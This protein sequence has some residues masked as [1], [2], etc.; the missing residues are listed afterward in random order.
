VTFWT[1][2]L[3]VVA[4]TV[5]NGLFAGAE[6]AVISLRRTRLRELV[7]EGNHA[8][9]LVTRLRHVPERFLATVQIGITVI[10]AT[11]AA[12]GGATLS[13]PVAEFFTKAGLGKYAPGLA[14]ASVIV[15]VSYLSLVLGELV[16]KSLALRGA[17]RYSLLVARPLLALAWVARPLVW[18]LTASSNL[19]L[20]FFG[21]R[22]NFVEARLSPEE[23][24]QLVEEAAQE[25]TVEPRAG[26]I[27]SRALELGRLRAVAVMLPRVAVTALNIDLTPGTE[28]RQILLSIVQD[29]VPVYQGSQD[30]VIG[31]VT[32]RDLWTLVDSRPTSLAPILRAPYY[33]PKSVLAV[34]VLQEMQR[35]QSQLAMV[36]NEHGTVVGYVTLEDLVEELVG[37]I[38]SEHEKRTEAIVHEPGGTALVDGTAALHEVNR[39]LDLNLSEETGATTLAGAVIAEHGGIPSVGTWLSLKDGVQLEVVAA[40]PRRVLRVR[41]HPAPGTSDDNG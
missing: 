22:T 37:E 11:A 18:L 41:V 40:D 21:D 3:I 32:M 30:N 9:M 34:D 15:L 33:V 39:E 26:E 35:R 4:L 36:V 1:E 6:I 38:F 14:F 23:L 10:G 27:A 29:R 24:Q 12:F 2:L 7:S 17:E 19:V 25:G 28:L 8:A 16:P 13:A 5:A 20:R 31:Y